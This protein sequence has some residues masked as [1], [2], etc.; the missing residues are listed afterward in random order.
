M[1]KS[2][3][4]DEQSLRAL[5]AAEH[6]DALEGQTTSVLAQERSKAMDYYQGDMKADMPSLEG[7]SAAIST[8]V[9]DTI[10]G[11]M[12][13]LMEI[14][15]GGDEV[16]SFEPVGPEDVQASQQES[17]YT[18]YIFMKQN[19]GFMVLYSFMKD[20]LLSKNGFVKIWFERTEREEKEQY[21]GLSD[22]QFAMIAVDPDVE[23]TEH[24][25]YDTPDESERDDD[26][27]AVGAPG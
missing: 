19:P 7:R 1:T 21:F 13:S 2:K 15:A 24:S 9:L 25:V 20:A 17:D 4:M 6:A 8:D 12:P 14:F 10:E 22:D 5:I 18:N 26:Q 16:I 3:Q 27:S 23:I 11:I